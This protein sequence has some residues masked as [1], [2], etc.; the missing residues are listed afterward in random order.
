MT[1][2]RSRRQISA[3]TGVNIWSL[4]QMEADGLL[5]AGNLTAG[6]ELVV[7]ALTWADGARGGDKEH[8]RNLAN[9]VRSVLADAADAAPTLFLVLIEGQVVIAK[10]EFDALLAVRG[11]RG[12]STLLPLGAWIHETS[13]A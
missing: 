7:R 2:P 13:A 9:Q 8:E 12:A 5:P 3:A 10:D 4:R 11:R 1:A 6:D